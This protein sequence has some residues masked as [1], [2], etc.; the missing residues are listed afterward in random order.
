M[1]SRTK[2]YAALALLFLESLIA[3]G[4]KSVSIELE[5]VEKK[6]ATTTTTQVSIIDSLLQVYCRCDKM[7]VY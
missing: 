3:S 1:K 2:N 6:T 5:E 7:F 4:V